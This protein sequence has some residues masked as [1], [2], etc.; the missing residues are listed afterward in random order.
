MA[1]FYAEIHGSA[2]TVASRIGS[3]TTG[4]CTVTAS[5]A[6]AIETWMEE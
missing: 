4:I 6:G 1:H 2:R 5:W 3:K